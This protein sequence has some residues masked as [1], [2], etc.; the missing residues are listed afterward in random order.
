MGAK[1]RMFKR[2]GSPSFYKEI[3][4]PITKGKGIQGIGF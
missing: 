2:G 1:H 4:L 3:P